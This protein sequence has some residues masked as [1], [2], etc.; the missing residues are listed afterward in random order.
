MG[1]GGTEELR[2]A[3]GAG[4]A[5]ASDPGVDQAQ[6]Q[7]HA[8]RGEIRGGPVGGGSALGVEFRQPGQGSGAAATGGI[9]PCRNCGDEPGLSGRLHRPPPAHGA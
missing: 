4:A 6:G 7:G 1:A 8:D 5:V 9:G 3:F 2:G